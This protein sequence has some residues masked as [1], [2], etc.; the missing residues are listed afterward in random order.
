M[1]PFFLFKAG[2][3]TCSL[4]SSLPC[5]AAGKLSHSVQRTPSDI[6]R[7]A[8]IGLLAGLQDP[9][10]KCVVVVVVVSSKKL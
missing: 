9:T 7:Q 4:S 5:Q 6:F 10:T 2:E 8:I 3:Q 1:K